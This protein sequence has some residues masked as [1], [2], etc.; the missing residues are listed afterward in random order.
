MSAII[1]CLSGL[2]VPG[3]EIFVF[4][5]GSATNNCLVTNDQS[6][7]CPAPGQNSHTWTVITGASNPQL[8]V[9]NFGCG[10]WNMVSP[11]NF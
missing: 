7:T 8:A 3:S 9:G 6:G 5:P 11:D 10:Q 4:F 1:G 2:A